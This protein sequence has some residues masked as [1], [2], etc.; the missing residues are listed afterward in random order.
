[1]EESWR[2]LAEQMGITP[3]QFQQI[4]GEAQLLDDLEREGKL[5]IHT[6]FDEPELMKTTLQVD[7]EH[8][9]LIIH[10]SWEN[11]EEYDVILKP[12]DL[13]QI[14]EVVS[15]YFECGCAT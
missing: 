6:I 15:G 2:D 7:I 10:Q 5:P 9:I 3:E 11:G 1:M 4:A 13:H 14:H 8:R 12:E